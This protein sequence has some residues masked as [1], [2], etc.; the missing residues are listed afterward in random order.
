MTLLDSG[1]WS[2]KIFGDGWTAATREQPV[3]EPATGDGLGTVGLATAEEVGR[4]AARA[5]EAQRAWA[6]TPAQARAAV[7]RRAGELF[8]EHAAEIEDWLV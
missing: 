4:A 5:A 1:V 2:K 7:L 8:T 6:A 3:V